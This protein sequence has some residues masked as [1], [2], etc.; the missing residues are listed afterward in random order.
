MSMTVVLLPLHGIASRQDLPLPFGYLVV[1]AALTLIISFFVLIF[2]WRRPRYATIGG[3]ALP[4]LTSV[5]DNRGVRLAARLLILAAYGW[6]TLASLFGKDLLTN[7]SIGFVFVWVW[8]GLVP[9]SLLLGQFCRAINPLRTV[10]D[11][12]SALARIDPRSGL[13]ALPKRVGVWPAAIGL[14]AFGW[15]DWF[16]RNVRPWLCCGSGR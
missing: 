9:I 13:L 7:P 11:G 15:L 12:L 14:F 3:R 6:A 2:A 5:I 16:S 1:G 8:V 10:H 4:G